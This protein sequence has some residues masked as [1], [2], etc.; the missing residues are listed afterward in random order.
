MVTELGDNVSSHVSPSSDALSSLLPSQT[1][2]VT[3]PADS[4]A[5]LCQVLD[6]HQHLAQRA[7]FTPR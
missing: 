7:R 1:G 4:E 5:L 3:S 6:C 2:S